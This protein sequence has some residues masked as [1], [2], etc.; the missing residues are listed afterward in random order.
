MADLVHAHTA[1]APCW[2][3]AVDIRAQNIVQALLFWVKS[4]CQTLERCH[5]SFCRVEF[6]PSVKVQDGHADQKTSPPP[7]ETSGKWVTFLG[8]SSL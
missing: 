6:I 7:M 8:E 5:T 2:E 3:A 1:A 4:N